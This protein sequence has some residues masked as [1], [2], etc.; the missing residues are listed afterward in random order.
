MAIQ[1]A[2]LMTETKKK[3]EFM[4]NPQD[5]EFSKTTTWG[6]NDTPG[7]N[8]P[9]L[10]FNSGGSVEFSLTALFDS[11]ADGKP[12]TKI[13]DELYKLTVTDKSIKGTKEDRNMARPPWV[14]FHW[15]KMRSFKAVV[16]KLDL[17]FTY[18][19]AD[20]TP[21]RASVS[22]SF[23]QYMD[24]GTLAPQNPTSGTPNPGQIRRVES[25]QYLDTIADELYGD[26]S[27]WRSIADANGID[28]PLA[29]PVGKSLIIP[30]Q[31]S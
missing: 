22:M 5:L 8:A 30:E 10:Q 23:R 24:E 14:Q 7:S 20:G 25:G 19:T 9:Q 15:G 18:F 1:K 31:E 16:T 3:I 26:S 6:S 2:Y 29:I 21:L 12:V 28:D 13:T 11:T 4:F 17:K 27:K